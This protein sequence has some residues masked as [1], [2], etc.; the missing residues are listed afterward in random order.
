MA[1][2]TT[3]RPSATSSGVGWSAVPSGT[4]HGVTS[5]DS[6]VTYALWSGA[7]SP[8]ILTT[9]ADAPPVG[10]RRHLVRMRARGED[11]DAFWAVRLANGALIA[12]A[13]A[14]FSS[15]PGTVNGS[16]GAGAPLDGSTVLS[17]YV[18]GQSASVKVTELYIDVDTRQAPNFTP[19]IL[20][21][22]G[23]STIIVS[24]TAQPIVH[25][26]V[27]DLDGLTG[28]NYRYWVTLNGAIVWDTGTVSGSPADRMTS[29]LDNGTYV[30]HL[31]VWSRLGI[32]TAYSSGEKTITFTVSVGQLAAPENPSVTPVAD[33]PF[34]S[35]EG[36]APLVTDLDGEVGYIEI[37]RVDCPVGGYLQMSTSPGA[38]ASTPNPGPPVGTELEI[39]VKAQ[40]TDDWRPADDEN[41]ISHYDT[42]G[43]QRGWRLYLDS[44]GAGDPA[45][46]GRPVL[47]WSSD[48]VSNTALR[49]TARIPI[50]PYGIGRLKVTWVLDDGLGGQLLTFWTRETDDAEW[51]VL[52]DPFTEFANTTVFDN[53]AIPY[54]VGAV[55]V[56]GVASERFDGRIYSA[57]VRSAINGPVVVNPDFT[58]HLDGTTSFTDGAG[59][60]WTVHSPAAITSPESVHTLAMLGPLETDECATY[61]DY[62]LPRSGVGVTCDHA[63]DQ[64]CSYYRARTV[65]RVDGD[66]RI[67]EWSDVFDAGIPD[68]LIVMWP[69][70]NASI[71]EGWERTTAL[72]AKYPKGVATSATQPGTTGGASAHTHTTP[73]H[74]HDVSHVHTVTGNT[75]AAT[76]TQGLTAGGATPLA[77]LGTH[78]HSRSA[79]ASSTVA[80][81]STAPTSGSISNDPARLEVIF[82]ES[83]GTPL[84]VPDGALVI[85]PDISL[86]GWTDY[87]NADGR[88]LK[89][90][91]AAGNGG[92][93]GAD[94]E[95]A[96]FHSIPGH[97]HTGTSHT[98]TSPATG[99]AT[100]ATSL[101]AGA[102]ATLWQ[103]GHT[104][105]VAVGNTSAAA[106]DS[107]GGGDS[108]AALAD[109]RPPFRN[110]RVK[111]NTSGVPDLPV[112]MI[113]AWR[114]SLGSIPENWALCDGTAGTPD[115]T[116]R[117][118]RGATTSIG[119]AGGSSA[120]HTH[121][122]PS[123][124]HGT[125]GHTH[126]ETIAAASVATANVGNTNTVTV[127]N[128]THT[129]TAGSTDSTTPSVVN[130][131]SGT[132]AST[133]S[134]PPFEEV[135]FV[136]LVEEPSPPPT[137]DTFCLTWDDD[138]HLIRSTGPDGALWSPIK[139][140]FEWDVDRPFTAATGVNGSRFVTSAPPGGRNLA[141]AAAVESEA[142]LAQLQEVLNRPLVLISPSD[143]NEVWAA[144]V[145]ASVRIVKVGR[146]RQ[147]TAQFIATGP[148]PPP[149]LA[150]VA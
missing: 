150:D 45:L 111:E 130:A 127:A 121:A 125:S 25:A 23:A 18:T 62:S 42:A 119:T 93:T 12:G 94:A 70:T 21:G 85:T 6:D 84:G 99:S 37:Q 98:H 50:D 16:W 11:G 87:A 74:T 101:T 29:A 36:C 113:G 72:D 145:T 14:Q 2:I 55:F 49:A 8:M 118:P 48:G 1:T 5:D 75:A 115:L 140:K 53:T 60:L 78:T 124:N 137:P 88:F 117:Y 142:E 112:G 82:V 4:L 56:A 79:V 133:A 103:A 71:P 102:T 116:A 38:Y 146:I 27:L 129:H 122:S 28:R 81:G 91:A 13:S 73:G 139:G 77:I 15:S 33:T 47:A 90:A 34:Y 107:G 143:A 149:Q 109:M 80:S 66:L 104:H 57:E 54:A 83:N 52:G 24:D 26:N 22:S 67:S 3:L 41:L 106:L 68:G 9:P 46:V 148:Q 30:A 96:H 76:G 44:D 108:G 114:G 7:G 100:S 105:A 20:D 65:G 69:S 51:T 147:V 120:A 141:M 63:P 138:E 123:H 35:I 110:V 126:T 95:D 10:E 31:V 132:L 58:G 144:P 40:R 39:Q 131:T 97:T 135:A 43:N 134:E 64:C 128:P 59:N 32:D 89:G 136:Q 19:Q 92:A 86:S 61:V 17:A